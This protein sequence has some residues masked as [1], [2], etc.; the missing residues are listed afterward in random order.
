MALR[1]SRGRLAP[2][3]RG[4]RTVVVYLLRHAKAEARSNSG[5][6]EDRV[7]TRRGVEQAEYIASLLAEAS[8]PLMRPARI[9]SSPVVRAMQTARVLASRLDLRVE[10]KPGL[11]LDA[12]ARDV[13]TLAARLV[14]RGE[15]VMLIGHNP[16]FQSAV[17]LLA[18]AAGEETP[19]CT[20]EL[21]ALGEPLAADPIHLRLVARV[22]RP[23]DE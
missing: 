12:A 2:A 1:A 23:D 11:G 13:A 6:D 5:R 17:A 18:P 8:P 7:L 19:L 9:L 14:A 20:G 22:R 10:V 15:P 3:S 4:D 21:V 16:T